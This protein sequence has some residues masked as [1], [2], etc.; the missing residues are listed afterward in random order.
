MTPPADAFEAGL[1]IAGA[2]E[3]HGVSYALGGALAYGQYGSPRATNDVDVNVFVHEE[4]LPTVGAALRALG[5]AIDDQAAR[6]DAEREGLIVVKF[7]DFRVDVFTPSIAFSWEAERT[8]VRYRI[9]GRD[10]WFLSAEALA[11]FK[12]LFFRNKDLVDLERLLAVS[13]PA[14]DLAYVRARLVE[15]MGDDD[16]RVAA[17]DRLC[18]DHLPRR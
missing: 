18:A 13:G 12:L 1:R 15:M 10:V 2:L 7:A 4:A 16:P 11:V 5:I 3:A 6:R 9:E 14:I 17:W 8:R